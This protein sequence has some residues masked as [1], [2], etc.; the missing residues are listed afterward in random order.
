MKNNNLKI[1][2]INVITFLS[3]FFLGYFKIYVVSEIIFMV[4]G[5]YIPIILLITSFYFLVRR[6]E[7]KDLATLFINVIIILFVVLYIRSRILI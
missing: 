3:I 6:K 7:K 4:L 5:F 2:I 1:S